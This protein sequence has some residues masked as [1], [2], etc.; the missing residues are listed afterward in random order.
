M[1]GNLQP[2]ELEINQAVEI[3]KLGG[4]GV[5]PTETVYG[6]A[7]HALDSRAVQRVFEI[8]SRPSNH[9]LIV[10]IAVPG[11]ESQLLDEIPKFWNELAG[12]FWPGALTLIGFK[13]TMVPDA[14]TAGLK[15]VAIRCP[16]HPIAQKVINQSGLPV[17]APSANLFTQISPTQFEMLSPKI[18]SQVDFALD[19]GPCH[20][21]IESTV[22][23]LTE[24]TPRILR[25][26]IISQL[27]IQKVLGIKIEV[28]SRSGD[29][30]SPGQHHKHY[31]PHAKVHLVDHVEPSKPG[32]VFCQPENQF[33]IQMSSE[34]SEYARDLY[35]AMQ[36]LDQPGTQDIYIECPPNS[37]D[38]NAI[39]DR[40]RRASG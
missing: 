33:Q 10:H 8:K 17:A 34:P 40:L 35:A 16:S 21:G 12:N 13:N 31:S 7:C 9:P 4:V 30:K 26:G 3:L 28:G 23:D 19:G 11:Q 36:K 6:L 27:E 24:T 15:T 14:V 32:I 18:L 29:H 37:V 2:E 22:L 39:W 25:Q 1:G 38:W 5:I 20:I